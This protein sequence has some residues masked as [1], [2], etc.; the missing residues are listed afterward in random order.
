M[1][2]YIFSLHSGDEAAESTGNG[3]TTGSLSMAAW[4]SQAVKACVNSLKSNLRMPLS[5]TNG[6]RADKTVDCIPC[7]ANAG[8]DAK[9]ALTHSGPTPS[10][11]GK[12]SASSH[13]AWARR[14]WGPSAPRHRLSDSQGP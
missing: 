13:H 7:E 3:G 11:S 12:R 14:Q 4:S 9:S 1:M 5:R 6:A 2:R 8:V 10:P